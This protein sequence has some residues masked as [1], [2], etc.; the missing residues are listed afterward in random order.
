MKVAFTI[1]LLLILSCPGYCQKEIAFVPTPINF[2]IKNAGLEVN[3]FI[4]GLEGFI[5]MDSQ[6]GSP[7]K[8]EGTI[9]PNTIQTGITLRDNHLK[10]AD[11]FYVKEF[12]KIRMTSTLITKKGKGKYIGNFDLM[13]KDIKKNIAIPFTL[14]EKNSVYALKGGFSIN[15][16][17]FN[18]GEKSIILSDNVDVN[19]EFKTHAQAE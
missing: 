3:G 7:I 19:L 1:V 2:I 18:L 14:S 15:R 5:L 16:L 6:T 4:E 10:K 9:D 11:Y 13:I 8:I 17:D 12:P